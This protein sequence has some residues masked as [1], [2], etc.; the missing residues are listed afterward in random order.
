MLF[1][2]GAF[3]ILLVASLNTSEYERLDRKVEVDGRE[4]DMVYVFLWSQVIR[5]DG[6]F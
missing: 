2:L 5:K 4:W 1:L 6:S 3:D